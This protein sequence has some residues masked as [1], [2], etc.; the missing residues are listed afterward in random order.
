[1]TST[2]PKDKFGRKKPPLHLIP[3]T[4][5]ILESLAMGNGAE[6]YGPYNWRSQ[7]VAATVYIAATM[8]HLQAWLDGEENA[9]DSDIHHLAHA[10]ASL[11]ILLDAQELGMMVD[12]RPIAGKAGELLER[13][14]KSGPIEP[15]AR[16]DDACAQLVADQI[17]KTPGF[18]DGF[19]KDPGNTQDG[20]APCAIDSFVVIAATELW[21]YKKEGYVEAVI[22]DGI[23]IPVP[24]ELVGKEL[25]IVEKLPAAPTYKE[26]REKRAAKIL[27][28]LD[29][30]IDALPTY[31]GTAIPFVE[32]LSAPEFRTV[33]VAGPMRGYE[34]YNFPAFDAARDQLKDAGWLVVSP[35][36]IDREAGLDPIA[37]PE[38][39]KA[40]IDAWT[41]KDL[42]EVVRRDVDVILGLRKERGDAICMLSGWEKSTG[43]VA[44]FFLARWC[45]LPILLR[46]RDSVYPMRSWDFDFRTLHNTIRKYLENQELIR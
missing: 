36:D 2:N 41:T 37:D 3:A 28:N 21:S 19:G 4:A 6:K 44:E 22:P 46:N 10:R 39:C 1:M 18:M 14:T 25:A 33:Y 16:N 27:V 38:G 24:D 13:H 42:L 12:D 34:Y 23:I 29:A 8:R 43:A 15:Q 45:G 32:Q 11:G 20:T 35:A 30:E 40:R 9:S 7:T 31:Q 26:V 5:T 17:E